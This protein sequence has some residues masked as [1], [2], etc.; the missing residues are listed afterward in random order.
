MSA[1]AVTKKAKTE[2][3]MDT[4]DLI[5]EKH[6]ALEA[7]N[8]ELNEKIA[9]LTATYQKKK[10]PIYDQRDA[11][12]KK[13][14]G[15]WSDVLLSHPFLGSMIQPSEAPILNHLISLKASTENNGKHIKVTLT[16]EKNPYFEETV[17]VKEVKVDDEVEIKSE[18]VKI[19]WKAGK[20]PSKESSSPD[21]KTGDKRKK[22][23]THA[24]GEECEDDH[25]SPSFFNWLQGT[26]DVDAEQDAEIATMIADDLYP[27]AVEYAFG[28]EESDEDGDAEEDLNSEDD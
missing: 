20:N 23:H 5:V 9:E 2:T 12:I 19:T 6:N 17:L 22:G 4:L 3:N 8:D 10:Q 26:D 14:P 16:F 21:A 18:P 27:N 1:A 24:D 11:L 13:V 28:T 25:D 7:V 15:F